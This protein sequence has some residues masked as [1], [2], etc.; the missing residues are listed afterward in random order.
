MAMSM[1]EFLAENPVDRTKVDQHK[2]RMLSEVR[3][4]RLRELREAAGLTQQQLADL[5]GVTQ[6]QVSKLEHGD[7]EST[8][9]GGSSR[10]SAGGSPLSTS[11]EMPASKSPDHT[12][13]DYIRHT[14][15]ALCSQHLAPSR[16]AGRRVDRPFRRCAEISIGPVP[17]R[18]Q[19]SWGSRHLR[20]GR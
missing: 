19:R 18:L 15:A 8:K 4:H 2:E 16:L 20:A 14:L 1:K 7:L 9:V 10:P 3:A 12:A 13:L 5:I 6:R 17:A 11:L